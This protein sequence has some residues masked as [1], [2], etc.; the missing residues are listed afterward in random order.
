LSLF[1]T[2]PED[3]SQ[4]RDEA[5]THREKIYIFK[6]KKIKNKKYIFLYFIFFENSSLEVQLADPVVTKIEYPR[7]WGSFICFLF[8]YFLLSI[9]A[10]PTSYNLN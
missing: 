6:N 7:C 2:V 10:S 1:V 3:K 8:I 4:F 9:R 5:G